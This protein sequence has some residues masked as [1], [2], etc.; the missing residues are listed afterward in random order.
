MI[1]Q[2]MQSDDL[3]AVNAIADRVHTDYP[4]DEAVFA[5][6]LNIYPAG[7]FTLRDDKLTVGYIISHPW[8]FKKPPKLNALIDAVPALASTYYIHDI[9]L[10]PEAR[11][12]GAASTI[13]KTLAAHAEDQKSPNIS[14]VAVN[15]SVQF[16]ERHN[17]R[18]LIDTE[19]DKQLKSYDD[20]AKFMVREI[21]E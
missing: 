15:N 16:W 6:R 12:T 8:H 19:L 18:V 10:L 14:L 1:W 7:C 13:V 4:E 2:P 3:P 20:N 9:A 5:E 17:F 11:N 21:H